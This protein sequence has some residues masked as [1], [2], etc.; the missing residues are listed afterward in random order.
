MSGRFNVHVYPM[1][2]VLAIFFC[3]SSIP[4]YY[5]G[6]KYRYLLYDILYSDYNEY[7]Y[8]MTFL[9]LHCNYKLNKYNVF[10]SLS[11]QIILLVP[12]VFNHLFE[13]IMNLASCLYLLYIG[14]LTV[15]KDCVIYK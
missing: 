2:L 9:E 7:M 13:F 8:F 11:Y 6:M 3:Q 1:A 10:P 15:S 12:L 4:N 14:L 5:M